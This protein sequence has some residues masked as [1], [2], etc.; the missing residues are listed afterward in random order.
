MPPTIP[1]RPAVPTDF[2]TLYK[3]MEAFTTH[4][5]Y[6][7]DGPRR[8]GCLVQMLTNPQLGSL[9]LI[10]PEGMPV[11]YL[12]LNYSFSYEFGGRDAFI[13]ELYVAESHRNQGWGRVALSH[14]LQQGP[15]LGLVAINLQT[16]SYNDRAKALYTGVG[17][18]DLGRSTL[19]F[20]L[21]GETTAKNKQQP[22]L[23]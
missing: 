22:S 21:S 8:R 1:V 18:K 14:I 10:E 17:F 2:E 6:P 16:E 4:F 23:Q 19:T 7:F 12:A 20:V 13:D 9:W 11:G 15:Q 3:L 5:S